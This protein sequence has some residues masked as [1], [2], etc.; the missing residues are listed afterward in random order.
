MHYIANANA[1]A[2]KYAKFKTGKKTTSNFVLILQRTYVKTFHKYITDKNRS[3][4]K[5]HVSYVIFIFLRTKES[6]NAKL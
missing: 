1:N 2:K 6:T 5:C 4:A 3:A